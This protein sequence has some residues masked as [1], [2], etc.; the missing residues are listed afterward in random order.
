M[1]TSE[2]ERVFSAQSSLSRKDGEYIMVDKYL[3]AKEILI[4]K[5]V[6]DLA[7]K[8]RKKN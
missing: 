4:T 8:V 1:R 3:Y 2:S 5:R 6:L 7:V